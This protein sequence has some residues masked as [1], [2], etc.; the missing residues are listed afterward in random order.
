MTTTRNRYGS[1]TVTLQGDTEIVI[2]RQFDAPAALL[3]KATTTPEL[4]QRWWGFD[5]SEWLVCDIDLRV[6]GSWRYVTREQGGLEIAFHGEYREIDAPHRLV[7]TELFEGIPGATEADAAVNTV[8]FEEH[9]GV[10]TMTTTVVHARPEHRDAHI[11]SGME[12]GMQVSMNRLEDLV[13]DLGG[14]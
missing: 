1:A 12:G 7:S 11:G 9:D 8:T 2:A 4:V 6:G 3:F 14:R 10:T 5:T 13:L